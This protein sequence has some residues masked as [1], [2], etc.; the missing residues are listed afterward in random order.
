LG[1]CHGVD[2]WRNVAPS[3][4]QVLLGFS[5]VVAHSAALTDVMGIA[6]GHLYY[7]LEDFYPEISGRRLLRTP[8]FMYVLASHAQPTPAWSPRI[9]RILHK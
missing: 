5:F 1:L 4:P 9:A 3:A 7:Y 6:V 8:R 2:A